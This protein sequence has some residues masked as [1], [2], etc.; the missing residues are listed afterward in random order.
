MGVG[1]QV[2]LSLGLIVL[3]GVALLPGRRPPR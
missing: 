3:A 2:L 1:A